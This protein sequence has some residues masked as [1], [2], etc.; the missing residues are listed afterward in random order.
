[1]R[2]ILLSAAARSEFLQEVVY[3]ED[4]QRGLGSRFRK[5]TTAAFLK[6]AEFPL[7]GKPGIADTRRVLVD[8]FPFAVVYT[9]EE[10]SIV[11]HAVAH[12]SRKPRYWIDR[13]TD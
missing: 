3:Y 1:V 9:V 12:L 5:A 13:L 8:G 4:I 6:S 7:H 11:V 2:K 10:A